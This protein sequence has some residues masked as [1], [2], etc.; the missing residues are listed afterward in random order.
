MQFEEFDQFTRKLCSET[1][2]TILHYFNSSDLETESKSDDTP[3]TIADRTSEQTIRDAI[4][5]AYPDH[6]IV[7]E[8]FADKAS[9]SEYSWVIDP[10]DG[11]KTFVASCP[12]FGTMIALLKDGE[13]IYGC[14]NYPAIGKRICGD[15]QRAFCNDSPIKART[16]VSIDDSVVLVTDFL[17]VGDHQNGA[18]FEALARRA[19]LVR[20]WGDCYGY[21]LLCEGKADIM[22]DPEMSPWDIMALI[23]IV[24]GAGATITDWQ[25]NN[26]TKGE[27]IIAANSD[28]HAEVQSFLNP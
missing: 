14:I 15:G 5:A 17:S 21:L 1:E 6:G 23:P 20:T 2:K 11:T 4:E 12:L 18:T 24:R 19:R 9:K 3:V 10:I 28:L 8:E 27:S 22:L 26:P 25:G 7:G 13:P 16:G